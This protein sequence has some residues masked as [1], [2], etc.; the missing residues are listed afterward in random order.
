[1][2]SFL[3]STL[4]NYSSAIF[5]SFVPLFF[6][7][8]LFFYVWGPGKQS[9]RVEHGSGVAS[10]VRTE[11]IAI[12]VSKRIVAGVSVTSDRTCIFIV[13]PC[14]ASERF[15]WRVRFLSFGIHPFLFA[16]TVCQMSNV[17]KRMY[18]NTKAYESGDR[19]ARSFAFW[20]L[21]Q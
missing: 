5:V 10:V 12:C 15:V 18:S 14:A 4:G 11:N 6:F 17:Y 21:A 1:M 7:L 16:G 20:L 19:W 8:S 9:T 2:F 13:P 3:V